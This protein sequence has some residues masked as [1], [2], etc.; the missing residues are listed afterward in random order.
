M[1]IFKD[2]L[3]AAGFDQNRHLLYNIAVEQLR[4]SG[5][6]VEAA[7]RGLADEAKDAGG[8]LAALIPSKTILSHAQGFVARVAK[9][10]ASP[11]GEATV[12]EPNKVSERPHPKFFGT[13]GYDG[14]GD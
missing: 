14:N 4:K 3:S 1:T 2:R 6:K 7:A 10:M 9:D 8:I 12:S 13:G 5:M 11:Q